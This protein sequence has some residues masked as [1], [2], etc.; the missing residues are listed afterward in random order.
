MKGRKTG[1][2]DEVRP[3]RVAGEPGEQIGVGRLD[4]VP[5]FLDLPDR[6]IEGLGQRHPGEPRRDADAQAA[7]DQ[8]EQRPAA[9]RVQPVEPAGDQAAHLRPAGAAQGSTTSA[10]PG[11][12]A[13]L[14]VCHS[15]AVVSARSPT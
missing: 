13:S 3:F 10:S 6:R 8:L 11:G 15:S 12:A 2:S 7:G 5:H 4:G 9:G 14:C 1:R